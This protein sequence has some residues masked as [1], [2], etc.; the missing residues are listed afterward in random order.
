MT[1]SIL[2]LSHY[3]PERLP[4][5][6]PTLVSVYAEV[7]ER[8]AA[9][10][11]FL[12]VPRFEERLTGHASR[13]GWACVVGDVEGE[14]VGYAYGRPDGEAEWR[15]VIDPISPG[16]YEYGVGRESFGL[17]EIMMRT[18]W[19]GKGIARAI[20]DDLMRERSEKR[21][22][23]FVDREHPRVRATYERWGYRWVAGSQP[24]PDSPLYDVMVLDLT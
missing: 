4:E 15:K 20:H 13:P 16:V 22:S 23:L 3:G 1:A 6:R 12:S 24:F 11:P 9:A 7:Y 10:D 8:E 19:R 14:V 2:T 18:P 21:A 5:I 17:C